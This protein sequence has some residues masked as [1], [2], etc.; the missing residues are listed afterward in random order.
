MMTE[1]YFATSAGRLC[2]LEWGK[3]G[4]D[5]VILALHGWL[6]NA[7]SFSVVGPA[8]Q[9][10]GFRFL[11]LDL[12]GHGLSDWMGEGGS[13]YIWETVTPVLEVIQ[14]LGRPV[15]LL[16]H[17]MGATSAMLL[18]A[19]YPEKA[20]SLVLLDA[21]GP[22]VTPAERTPEQ[23]RKGIDEALKRSAHGRSLLSCY[24]SFEQALEVR[25]KY[26]TSLT[27]ECI[28]P[29]VKR[30]LAEAEQGYQWRTDPRLRYSSRLRLTEE[31]VEA[32]CRSIDCFTLALRAER[33]IIPMPLYDDRL[34][35]LKNVSFCELPGHHH[36]HLDRQYADKVIQELVAFYREHGGM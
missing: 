28:G 4:N 36:F 5:H 9:Q 7:A 24:S 31:Q 23:M 25:V 29:V 20:S 13:Y 35:Y 21:I 2:A 30:N 1:R 10:S 34:P 3:P 8:L 17:S 6:D 12:P 15:H 26:G 16:G 33:S 19:C 32:F 18:A 22:V 27:P 14:Q 11:A